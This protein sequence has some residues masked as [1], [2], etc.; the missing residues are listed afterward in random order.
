VKR[1]IT[2]EARWTLEV[3]N[4][5]VFESKTFHVKHID[6]EFLASGIRRIV[7][8]DCHSSAQY[9]SRETFW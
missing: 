2:N 8:W 4:S 1:F 3:L 7:V 9:A 6:V 5:S